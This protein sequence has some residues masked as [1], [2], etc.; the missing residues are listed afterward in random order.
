MKEIQFMEKKMKK[1]VVYPYEN[2][3]FSTI[4]KW[5]TDKYDEVIYCIP[6]DK[7]LEGK[8]LSILDNREKI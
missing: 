2:R 8:D 7:F 5:V 1:I 6:Q 4:E 3:V